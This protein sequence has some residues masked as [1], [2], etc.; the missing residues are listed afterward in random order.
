MSLHDRL[1]SFIARLD[2][3]QPTEDS[4]QTCS[5]TVLFGNAEGRPAARS[6]LHLTASKVVMSNPGFICNKN[7]WQH[8]PPADLLHT[9]WQQNSCSMLFLAYYTFES[10]VNNN[11]LGYSERAIA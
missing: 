7:K 5:L 10:V 6:N 9:V 8:N 1:A 4:H 2:A 11:L 3:V